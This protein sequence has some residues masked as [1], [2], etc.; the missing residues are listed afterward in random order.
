MKNKYLA[1]LASV[2]LGTM[3]SVSFTG[4]SS[5]NNS[6]SGSE[7]TVN[8]T[9]GSSA[10]SFTGSAEGVINTTSICTD[11][12][13]E[14]TADLTGA[15]NYTVT[16]GEGISITEEGVY[17]LTGT[18]SNVTVTVECEDENAKVQIVLNGVSITND[19]APVIYVKAA[20]KVFVTTAEGTENNLAVTG[21]FTAD[22][23]TNTDAVI[24]SKDDIVL[25]GLGTLTIDSTDNAVSGKDDIKVT[26]GSYVFNV[27]GHGLEA[28]DHI[29]F[30]DGTME[31]TASADGFHCEND[32]DDTVGIIY[33]AGGNIT[34][35]AKDD[36]LH[37]QAVVQI[38]GGTINITAGEGI[39]ST[40]VQINDGDI[41][42]SATDDGINAGSKSSSYDVVIEINGGSLAIDMGSGDTDALDANGCLY[43]NGGT[44]DITA[45]FAFDFD[46][47]AQLNG[48]TVTVNGEEVTEITESMQMG[49]G[50]GGAGGKQGMGGPGGNFNQGGTEGS[51]DGGET[52]DGEMPSGEFTPGEMPSGEFTPGEM[53]SGEFTPGEDGNFREGGRDGRDGGRMQMQDSTA[54]NS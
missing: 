4:C 40:Y 17:V 43:I 53:P 50:M 20:D 25:N 29:Y 47:E 16:D 14:Q 35:S 37:G 42:I 49:G 51:A 21:E 13:L 5:E 33:V 3:V 9:G 23:D 34:V 46:K 15:T 36:G 22:G 28:N 32:E 24:F 10:S 2:L 41:S 52:F 54:E 44:V 45:Q 30:I 7:T 31:V 1:I 19:S 27:T 11:R 26:G 12:D 48:G 38:D 6:T 18:A 39:E 8:T